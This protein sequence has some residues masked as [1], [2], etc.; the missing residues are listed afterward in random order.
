MNVCGESKE[1]YS[2]QTVFNDKGYHYFTGAFNFGALTKAA[3]LT[4]TVL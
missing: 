2:R 3:H 4:Y 1:L